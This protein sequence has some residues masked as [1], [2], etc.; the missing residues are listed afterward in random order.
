MVVRNFSND[1]ILMQAL[2]NKDS[3]AFKQLYDGYTDVMYS[4]ALQILH[5]PQDAEDLIHEV[6][7]SIWEKCTYDPQRGSLKTFLLLRVRSRALDRLRHYKVQQKHITSEGHSL[8]D[9]PNHNIPLQQATTID[10]SERVNSAIQDLPENQQ[11]ALLMAYFEGYTQ[12]AISE[13]FDVPLGTVKSWF[14][15]S[16]KK[17]RTSLNNLRAEDLLPHK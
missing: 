16:F 2:L 1:A 8:K 4:L 3:D 13:H 7:L 6:F 5:K 12:Q 17:L 15:L 9:A 11:K 14:R 10:L